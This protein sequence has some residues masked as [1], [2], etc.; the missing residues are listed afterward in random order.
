M[1][2]LDSV[3]TEEEESVGFQVEVEAEMAHDAQVGLKSL[4]C[5]AIGI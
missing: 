2:R 3:D 1:T 5:G 4:P